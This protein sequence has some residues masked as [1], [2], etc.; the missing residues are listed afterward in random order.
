MNKKVYILCLGFIL[1]F[2]LF[3]S[4]FAEETMTIT[5]YYPS[6]YGSY[7]EL[8]TNKL[9]VGYTDSTEQPNTAGDIR[10]KPWTSVPSTES[11]KAGEVAYG[12]DSYLYVHNGSTWVKQGGGGGLTGGCVA[13]NWTTNGGA[14]W[15]ASVGAGWGK[16][17]KGGSLTPMADCGAVT[18]SGYSCGRS[19]L[20][21]YDSGS[22]SMR[23]Y[24]CLCVAQ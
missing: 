6:P 13:M 12:S 21:S 18:A 4:A 1:T 16:G 20:Y 10:L 8:S 17:C 2:G 22:T 3:S 19:S 7:N 15:S 5:T 14:S 24:Y 11:G 23:D 9:A